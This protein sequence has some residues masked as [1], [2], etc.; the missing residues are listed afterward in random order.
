MKSEFFVEFYC[1]G[2]C[3]HTVEVYFGEALLT[4]EVYG[5]LCE[6]AAKPFAVVFFIEV[7][8]FKLALSVSEVFER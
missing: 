4:R 3:G 7:E 2:R 6:C 8:R 1:G 5:G